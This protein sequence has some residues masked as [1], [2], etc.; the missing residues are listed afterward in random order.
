VRS[1]GFHLYFGDWLH[2]VMDVDRDPASMGPKTVVDLVGVDE[3]ARYVGRP[4]EGA[5]QVQEL[6]HP[7][8][9]HPY[10]RIYF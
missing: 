1:G 8:N 5:T 2:N 4:F 10:A 6:H 9:S 7:R 3:T